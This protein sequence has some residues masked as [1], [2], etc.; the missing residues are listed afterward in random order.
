MTG[1]ITQTIDCGDG[2]YIGGN[3]TPTTHQTHFFLMKNTELSLDQLQQVNG[4][5]WLS[6]SEIADY[7][8][9]K[10][11]GGTIDDIKTSADK[12]DDLDT[13]VY[14]PPGTEESRPGVFN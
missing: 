4:G 12:V 11:L 7:W 14:Q 5:C 10:L 9:K 2:V 3:Q 8:T 13:G 6:A 1:L